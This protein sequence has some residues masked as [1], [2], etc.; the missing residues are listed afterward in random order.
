METKTSS[1]NQV[2]PSGQACLK[3]AARNAYSQHQGLSDTDDL[4]TQYL[5]LVHKIVR[6]AVTYLRPPLS[7]E[8]LVSAGVVG[9]LKAARDYDSS[10]EAE[11]QTYAY[12]RV[13]GA[14]LDELKA[15]SF[16]PAHINKQINEAIQLRRDLTEQ[17]GVAPTDEELAQKLQVTVDKLYQIFSNTRAKNF[18]S[19]GNALEDD[20]SSAILVAAETPGPSNR[21]EKSELIQQLTEAIG[22]L[23]ERQRQ[24]I[25]LYYQ[26]ELTM[27]QI[28]E[29]F[30]LTEP[31][32][33]QLHAKAIFC[34]S[35]KMKQWKYDRDGL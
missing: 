32:V 12:I 24:I 28:A 27:K 3:A 21:M 1:L 23:D 33:S 5:P 16:L 8:D 15:H 11:F 4:V 25:V 14:V 2:D 31:R 30:G 19:Y 29:V 35:A 7:R 6:R 22:Q 17:R 18:L 34:L 26:Q 9:L 13:R 20:S 10:R